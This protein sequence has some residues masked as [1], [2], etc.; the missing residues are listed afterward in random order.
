MSNHKKAFKY[1]D[2]GSTGDAY[3]EGPEDL[4]RKLILGRTGLAIRLMT[5]YTGLYN[6]LL[7]SR[8]PKPTCPKKRKPQGKFACLSGCRVSKVRFRGII[9]E[10]ERLGVG[11]VV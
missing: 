6:Y 7:H 10:K 9:L 11:S 1:P 3:V 4:V 8:D 5:G 2:R